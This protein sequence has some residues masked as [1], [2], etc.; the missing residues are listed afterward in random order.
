MKDV[1]QNTEEIKI[2]KLVEQLRSEHGF[3]RENARKM[4]VAKGNK[5]L[6]FLTD[7]LKHPKHIYRWEA[8]KTM[9][10]IGA[11]ESLPY[12]LAALNDDKSDVRW[13]AAKG[14][15]KLGSQSV[16]PLLELVKKNEDSVFVLDSAHHVIYDLHEIG[17]LPGS[18]PAEELLNLLKRPQ[19]AGRLKVLL[20]KAIDGL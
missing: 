14:L 17:E 11:S 6:K 19:G 15:I 10:E 13:I 16:K 20:Y 4:L 9:E 8:V 18:F 7:L 12:F 3:E 5:S 2:E 1:N